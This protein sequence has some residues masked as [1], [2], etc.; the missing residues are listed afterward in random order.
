VSDKGIDQAFVAR[1]KFNINAFFQS[2]LETRQPS[3]LR[4][5]KSVSATPA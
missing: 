5:A 2:G 3:N 4:C 1:P